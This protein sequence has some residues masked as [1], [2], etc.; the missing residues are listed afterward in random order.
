MQTAEIYEELFLKWVI[1]SYLCD[2]LCIAIYV[3]I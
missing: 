2:I 3:E 1:I